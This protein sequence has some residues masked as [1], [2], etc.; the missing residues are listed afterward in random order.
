M[1]STT[2]SPNNR[3]RRGMSLVEVMV[4]T[5]LSV[6]IMSGVL[7]TT[8][9]IGRA[10]LGVRNYADMTAQARKGLELFAQD[11][12]QASEIVWNGA[13]SVTLTVDG[14]AVTYAYSSSAGTFSRTAAGATSALISGVT[15]FQFIGYTITGVDVSGANDLSAAAGRTAAAKITKQMQVSLTITRTSVVSASVTNAVLSARYTL[16]NKRVTA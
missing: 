13:N 7:T 12:R 11:T 15:S 3:R 8:L 14:T 2:R 5:A 16:R 4:A 1:T 6:M 9:M 10:G